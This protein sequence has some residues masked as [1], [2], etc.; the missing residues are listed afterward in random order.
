M[1]GRSLSKKVEGPWRKNNDVDVEDV[2]DVDNG[3]YGRDSDKNYC[4]ADQ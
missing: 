1:R 4:S 2:D 3:K